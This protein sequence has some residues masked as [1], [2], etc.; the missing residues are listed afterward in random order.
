M[1]DTRLGA[2]SNY[3]SSAFTPSPT[4]APVKV[5]LRVDDCGSYA[6]TWMASDQEPST[7]ATYFTKNSPVETIALHRLLPLDPVLDR[8]CNLARRVDRDRK[9]SASTT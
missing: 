5:R 9:F 2:G 6:R 4:G 8:G 7:W 1:D 3:L